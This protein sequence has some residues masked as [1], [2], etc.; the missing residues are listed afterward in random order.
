MQRKTS[1]IMRTMN[2]HTFN[3]A[4]KRGNVCCLF[5]NLHRNFLSKSH[6]NYFVFH[7]FNKN[8]DELGFCLA[9]FFLFRM[10]IDMHKRFKQASTLRMN[11]R[12]A[13][14]TRGKAE[15]LLIAT[16]RL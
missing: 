11:E 12:V 1:L 13:S 9:F 4:T 5:Q 16:G 8:H 2:Q 6:E 7:F 10:K 3:D 15:Q 14:R